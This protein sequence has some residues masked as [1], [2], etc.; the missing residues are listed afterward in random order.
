LHCVL[1]NW[2]L[3]LRLHVHDLQ[4]GLHGLLGHGLDVLVLLVGLLPHRQHLR[5]DLQCRL[6]R[7]QRR[8]HIL[9]VQL[10]DVRLGLDVLCLHKRLLPHQRCLRDDLTV[11]LRYICLIVDRHLRYL[12]LE[13]HHVLG[14][15]DDVH[16]LSVGPGPHPREHLRRDVSSGLV[17]AVGIDHMLVVLVVLLSLLGNVDDLHRLCVGTVPLE[18]LVLLVLPNWDLQL[19]LNRLYRLLVELSQLLGIGLN[20]HQLLDGPRPYHVVDLRLIVHKWIV[21]EWLDLHGLLVFVCDLFGI[22]KF[23]PYLPRRLVPLRHDLSRQLP[24]QHLS[25]RLFLSLVLVLVRQLHRLGRQ[26]VH[27]L[28]HWLRSL[29]QPVLHQLPLGIIPEH[30]ND[31]CCVLVFVRDMQR[32]FIDVLHEL[33]L[34]SLPLRIGRHL[35]DVLPIGNLQL[36]LNGLH[37][38]LVVLRQLLRIQHNM[39]KLSVWSIPLQWPV[40]HLILPD[41]HIR[42][43]R[44]DHVHRLL[45]ELPHLLRLGLNLHQLSDGSGPHLDCDV[46]TVLRKWIVR[47]RLDL[48]GLLDVVRHMP[49]LINDL[50]QL[51]RKH[52]PV[53]K[54]V[55]ELVPRRRVRDHV[56]RLRH[57]FLAVRDM[58]R[59]GHVVH[60]VSRGLPVLHGQQHLCRRLPLVDVLERIH[61][62]Q[63]RL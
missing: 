62:C 34:W 26:R 8:L 56:G 53:R 29:Q 24:F 9:C 54:C 20:M 44:I 16:E 35:H 21:C 15:I 55:P 63:L 7:K 12:L 57:V 28:P 5:Y 45:V 59:V 40:L 48:H 61:M 30:D 1:R 43:V 31:L 17:R 49:T 14:R 41:R 60:L 13:L 37:C 42:A 2:L 33:R 23:L 3:C 4:R 18:W 46:R 38:L 58:Q 19:E 10:P 27:Q 11:S 39:H 52:L 51:S 32:R 22:G 36:E 50:H 25:L 6:L 47:E